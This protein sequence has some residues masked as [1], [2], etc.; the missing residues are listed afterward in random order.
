MLV[1]AVLL[2][3]GHPTVTSSSKE[4]APN[5]YDSEGKRELSSTYV[6]LDNITNAV[7][8]AE[9]FAYL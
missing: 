2:R 6:L 5:P 8:L 4:L 9:N 3:V 7:N 1:N